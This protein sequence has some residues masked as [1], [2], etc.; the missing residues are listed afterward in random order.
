MLLW[1]FLFPAILS[2]IWHIKKPRKMGVEDQCYCFQPDSYP[3]LCSHHFLLFA[4]LYSPYH[5]LTFLWLRRFS[6]SLNAVSSFLCDLV[7]SVPIFL[8]MSASTG[9]HTKSFFLWSSAS[10]PTFSTCWNPLSVFY[11]FIY[12]YLCPLLSISDT[13]SWW[14]LI[15]FRNWF[16]LL[17]SL[18]CFCDLYRHLCSDFII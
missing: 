1:S 9:F 15:C 12:F 3:T 2:G 16:N 6:A 13:A 10:L 7:S 8:F 17:F 18:L 4:R 11:L 14:G 5:Y